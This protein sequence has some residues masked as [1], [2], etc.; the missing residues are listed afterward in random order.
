[1]AEIHPREA[2]ERSSRTVGRPDVAT[3][4][5]AS[6]DAVCNAD[7]MRSRPAA[8]ATVQ[9]FLRLKPADFAFV[10]PEFR[11]LARRRREVSESITVA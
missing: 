1:M 11:A 8:R 5:I 2:G 3:A 9:D 10:S 7:A 6:G 4:R